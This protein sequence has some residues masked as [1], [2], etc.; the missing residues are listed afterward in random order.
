MGGIGGGVG[1]SGGGGGGTGGNGS[2]FTIPALGGIQF[3]VASEGSGVGSGAGSGVTP[4]PPPIKGPR[5]KGGVGYIEISKPA[6]VALTSGSHIA[7][8]SGRFYACNGAG[9]TLNY[10]IP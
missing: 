1:G 10:C 6:K 2:Y 8:P 3:N 5:N 9:G 4:N 7:H